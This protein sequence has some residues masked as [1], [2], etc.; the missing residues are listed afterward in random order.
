MTETLEKQIVNTRFDENLIE[1]TDLY[2]PSHWKQYPP[3]TEIIR[4]YFEARVGARYPFTK[5]FGLQYIIKRYFA[6]VQITREKI[7]EA[8][9]NID[10][11]VGPGTFNIVG[12]NRLLEKHKGTIPI[13]ICAVPE[14]QMGHLY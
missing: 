1:L 7:D 14:G 4:S 13:R 9:V 11:A 12:W 2:K 3:G 10:A 5:F 8:Q 6:G